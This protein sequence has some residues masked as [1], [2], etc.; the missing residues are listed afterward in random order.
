MN[1]TGVDGR[2]DVGREAG[3]FPATVGGSPLVVSIVGIDGC[4][5]SSTF[6]AA[7]EA[8]AREVAVVGV[9]DLVLGG[10]PGEPVHE[11]T[12]VPRARLT[13]AVGRLAKG[14]RA[15]SLYKNVKFLDLTER[16]HLAR[17]VAKHEA[18]PVI[19]CDGDPLV[20]TAAWAAARFARERLAGDDEALDEGLA[21]LTKEQT[22]P[23]RE[24]PRELHRSWQLTLLNRLRLGR[25]TYPD[26]VVF[27]RID[28]ALALERI[29]ARGRPLQAHETEAFLGELD[30]SYERVC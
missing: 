20:N 6:E 22:V 23:L 12:D 25:F 2:Q 10:A 18:P 27:L 26:L 29:R 8:L 9:G 1:A 3:G 16:T 5:K 28:P 7:L 11:R 19:L 30:R 17:H 14:L 21:L 4:G 15:P 24:L 13:Q